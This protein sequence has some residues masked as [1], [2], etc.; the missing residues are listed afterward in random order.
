M[1]TAPTKRP[2]ETPAAWLEELRGA[3]HMPFERAEAIRDELAEHLRERIRDLE[4]EGMDEAAAA[5]AAVKELG[6]AAAV[7]RRF[8]IAVRTPLRRRVMNL[9]VIGLA[10]A[11]LMTSVIALRGEQ[12][13][14]LEPANELLERAVTAM[15]KDPESPEVQVLLEQAA[16][17]VD[18]A[19]RAHEL[20]LR[21]ESVIA[22]VDG[23]G[24]EVKVV[25]EVVEVAT[26]L[27]GLKGKHQEGPAVWA[28]DQPEQT[29]IRVPE[30]NAVDGRVGDILERIAKEAKLTP[31][32]R[33][34]KFADVGMQAED[35]VSI[36][37]AGG[38]VAE[39]VMAIN[40][41]RGI[42]EPT[43]E[44]FIDF[45][46]NE[47]SIEF[48]PRAYF[49]SRENQVVCYD[50]GAV[51]DAGIELDKLAELFTSFVEP[52]HWT[53]NGGDLASYQIVGRRLFVKAPPRMQKGVKWFVER[54]AEQGGRREARRSPIQQETRAFA[55]KHA[56]AKD[57]LEAISANQQIRAINFTTFVADERT[58]TIIGVATPIEHRIISHAIEALD[59][60]ASERKPAAA[61]EPGVVYVNGLVSRPGQ[62]AVPSGDFTVRRA[63]VAAELKPEAT[64]VMVLRGAVDDRR[65]VGEL[66]GDVLKDPAGTDFTVRPGDL[67]TVK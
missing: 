67:I 61:I 22:S 27:G 49:D 36:K 52:D 8:Q 3:L 4:L 33:W 30:L 28:G 59:V 62:Y 31:H 58:N 41:A 37:F 17:A 45:R 44:Q 63:L 42:A 50:V 60:P 57:V 55:I 65:I 23:N 18:R 35:V 13:P 12:S 66:V 40:E 21:I 6:D 7:A 39:A 64:R 15:Q 11:A 19:E 14:S 56:R 1:T 25:P 38:D 47:D 10:G 29:G 34:A 43:H 5:S 9:A 54:V 51:V 16:S 20:R 26:L 48:A 2:A 32:I 24:A 53:D 46:V